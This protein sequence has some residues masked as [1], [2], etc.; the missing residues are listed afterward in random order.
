M[1]DSNRRFFRPFP[2]A[3]VARPL[4][5]AVLW[6][7]AAAIVGGAIVGLASLIAGG[8]SGIGWMFDHSISVTHMMGEA[9]RIAAWVI[10]PI[11]IAVAVWVAAYGST[12]QGS[13]SRALVAAPAALALGVALLLLN[14]S[15]LVAAALALGWALAVPSTSPTHIAARAVPILVLA[16]LVPGLDDLSGWVIVAVLVA[17]PVAAGMAILVADVLWRLRADAAGDL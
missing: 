14:S 12:Q 3:G 7:F 13:M 6:A 11:G 8:V 10:A 4:G 1:T 2:V 9:L 16:L 17:S 15:G 5:V